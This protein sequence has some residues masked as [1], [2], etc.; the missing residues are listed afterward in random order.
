MAF[1]APVQEL[2]S[3]LAAGPQVPGRQ[4]KQVNGILRRLT[5]LAAQRCCSCFLAAREPGKRNTWRAITPPAQENLPKPAGEPTAR[6][7][8]EAGEPA[9]LGGVAGPGA[10]L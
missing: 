6:S 7:V 3:A 4:L 9:I 5:E 2:I 8:A 10:R 1:H